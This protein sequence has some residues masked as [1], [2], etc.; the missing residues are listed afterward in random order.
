MDAGLKTKWIEALRSG[1]YQQGRGTLKDEEGRFCCLGVLCDVM[2]GKWNDTGDA[3]V[4]GELQSFYLGHAAERAAGFRLHQQ[5]KL[6]TMN[7]DRVP[8]SA[9]A[10][11]IEQNL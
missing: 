6:W 1:N 2:G 3:E 10:D 8:F 5:E 11:Y 9:I 4:N 7:D